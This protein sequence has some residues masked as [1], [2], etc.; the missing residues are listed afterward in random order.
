MSAGLVNSIVAVVTLA[1]LA[2]LLYQPK[3]Q[4]SVIYK[5][6]VVPLAEIMDVGFIV[7]S[8]IIILLFG[9]AATWA[10]V[11]T[12]VLILLAGPRVMAWIR[13]DAAR[14]AAVR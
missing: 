11:F 14:R 6:T 2:R 13:F 8:P 10:S 12:A 3:V 9:Y 1:G 5:A 7:F 4:D